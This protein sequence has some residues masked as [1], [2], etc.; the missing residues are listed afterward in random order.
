MED[1]MSSSIFSKEREVSSSFQRYRKG[2]I[3]LRIALTEIIGLIA[4]YVS[5]TSGQLQSNETSKAL[6]SKLTYFGVIVKS[7]CLQ[8]LDY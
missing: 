8:R 1:S 2:D 7:S 4:G 5:L 6:A 3:Q